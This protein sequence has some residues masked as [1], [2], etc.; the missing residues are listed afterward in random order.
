MDAQLPLGLRESAAQ[1]YGSEGVD[2]IQKIADSNLDD[3][4]KYMENNG[5][6]KEVVYDAKVEFLRYYSIMILERKSFLCP[7]RADEF[8]HSFLMFSRKYELFCMS[9]HGSFVYHVPGSGEETESDRKERMEKI[10]S[11]FMD[12]YNAKLDFSVFSPDPTL[13]ITAAE[14]DGDGGDDHFTEG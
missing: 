8:W 1:R 5:Y 14:C 4:M 10:T 11:L 12:V 2:K 9:T 7:R 6:S 3:V 13:V